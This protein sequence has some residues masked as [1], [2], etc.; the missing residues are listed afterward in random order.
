MAGKWIKPAQ[1]SYR[2]DEEKIFD[3]TRWIG[4]AVITFAGVGLIALLLLSYGEARA[5][6]GSVLT[7]LFRNFGLYGLVACAAAAAGAL[8]GFLFAIPRT[9]EAATVAGRTDDPTAVKQAVLVANTNL[10]RVSDWLVT[11][12]LGATLVQIQ[13]IVEW[14]SKLGTCPPGPEPCNLVTPILVVY[15]SVLGFLGTYLVTRLYLTYALERTL[16]MLGAL[17]DGVLQDL[18]TQLTDAIASGEKAKLDRALAAFEQQKS[19]P[20]IDDN[21]RL[22][23]L[24]ARAASQRI[25]SDAA[26]DAT[27]KDELQKEILAAIDK[28]RTDAAVKA[29]AGT[30]PA[31]DDFDK[32][33]ATIR[34]EIKDRLK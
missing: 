24:V 25:T 26:I 28:A 33:D 32:L 4:R 14:V 20:G 31:K 21:A 3:A 7:V 2:A 10:E 16:L 27:R 17:P 29:E 11:L 22:N 30:S 1:A 18:Q 5:A 23:L 15:Y 12:L 9:R 34:A 6:S 19:R 8:F 13:P